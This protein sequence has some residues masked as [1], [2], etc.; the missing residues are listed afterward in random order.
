[1]VVPASAQIKSAPVCFNPTLIV[2]G[3]ASQQQIV[4][5]PAQQQASI[6]NIQHQQQQ[7]SKMMIIPMQG[8]VPNSSPARSSNNTT[9]KR[10]NATTVSSIVPAKVAKTYTPQAL[11]TV[12]VSAMNEVH[13]QQEQAKQQGSNQ[14]PRML[15]PHGRASSDG[16][17]TVSATSSPGADQQ[18]EINMTMGIRRLPTQSFIKAPSETLKSTAGPSTSNGHDLIAPIPKRKMR[19]QAK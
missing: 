12:N 11:S 1:M 7:S 18:E 9:S 17:T 2:D 6:S 19:K 4:T 5:I 13:K 16:S 15:S 14:P 10:R 3:S 8:N